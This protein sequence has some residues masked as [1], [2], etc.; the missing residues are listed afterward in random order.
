M[1][2]PITSSKQ[3]F[4]WMLL[5][6][7]GIV[8]YLWLESRILAPR[9]EPESLNGIDQIHLWLTTNLPVLVIFFLLNLVRLIKSQKPIARAVTKQWYFWSFV[10]GG[11]VVALLYRGLAVKILVILVL[12]IS[13]RAWK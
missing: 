2:E 4:I 12:M 7:F 1:S 10:F 3:T 6:A 13:G 9:P 11:W 8:I 5:N